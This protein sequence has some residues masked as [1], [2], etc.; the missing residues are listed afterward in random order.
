M[1]NCV[2]YHTQTTDGFSA[3][4]E[5]KSTIYKTRKKAHNKGNPL[6]FYNSNPSSLVRG[7]RAMIVK[8]SNLYS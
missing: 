2:P 7:E 1:T 3:T 8:S 4:V 5:G 6:S